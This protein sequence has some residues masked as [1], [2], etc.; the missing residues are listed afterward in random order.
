MLGRSLGCWVIL[1][2]VQWVGLRSSALRFAK[3]NEKNQFLSRDWRANPCTAYI[4]FGA[5]MVWL[6]SPQCTPFCAI[7]IVDHGRLLCY[8]RQHLQELKANFVIRGI[9][10]MGLLSSFKVMSV[11]GIDQDIVTFRTS[12]A[13]SV[14]GILFMLAGA[15]I[16]YLLLAGRL[17]FTLFTFCLFCL[18]VSAAFLLAG[19][20][21]M[22]YRKSVSLDR[23]QKKIELEESS[24][25]GVRLT[26]FH[27]DEV[28]NIE[29]T[30]D[31]EC[32][33]AKHASLWLVKAYIRH[34]SGF[35]VEKL[36]ASVSPSEAKYVAETI[37]ISCHKELII[38]CMT[39]ERL[40]FSQI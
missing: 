34:C 21:L 38:S 23:M 2:V 35:S 12:R 5:C 20:I 4:F 33:C 26:A 9:Q 14:L 36:F 28:M 17:F 24:I 16:I 6:R 13:C 29:L 3:K 19:L 25:L 1:L 22:T 18:F 32:I 37:S 8:Y 40:I 31:S 11:Q 10:E 39:N 30:R 15:G 7:K 27:F